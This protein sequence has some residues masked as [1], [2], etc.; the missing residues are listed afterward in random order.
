MG[1]CFCPLNI[2]TPGELYPVACFYGWTCMKIRVALMSL[3]PNSSCMYRASV[4]AAITWVTKR[5]SEYIGCF[6][7]PQARPNRIDNYQLSSD[8]YSRT[9][10][11]LRRKTEPFSWRSNVLYTSPCSTANFTNSVEVL[12]LSLRRIFFRCVSTV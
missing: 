5:V 7:R 4:R 10:K 11:G 8:N 6:C 3:W 2:M 12:K 9:K 1:S